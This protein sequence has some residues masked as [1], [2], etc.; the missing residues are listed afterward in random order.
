MNLAADMRRTLNPVHLTPAIGM[1]PDPWQ[2]D[3]LQSLH[4]RILLN[5]HRQAGKS[6]VASVLAVHTAIYEPGSTV[7]LVSPALRQ[8]QE[9]FKKCLSTYRAL[10]RPV[11][12]DAENALSLY[13]ENQSR[14]V[15]LPGKDTTIRGY[16]AVRLIIIDEAS[17]VSDG[18]L[19]ALRPMLAVSGGRL[20]ALST[21]RGKRGWWWSAWENESSSWKRVKVTADQCP[22]ISADFLR[23]ERLSLGER[24]WL[25]EYFGEF[26]ETTDQAFTNEAI[27]AAFDRDLEPLSFDALPEVS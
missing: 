12:A 26:V 23:E 9:I 13:L 25:Q 19:T 24:M 7:L 17:V 15:S 21:P 6:T 8:S 10:G 2:V 16:S 11:A 4:P 22:R 3:I 5:C 20:I 14:I 18:L 27:N 1:V